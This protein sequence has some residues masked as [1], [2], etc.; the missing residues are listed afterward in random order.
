M[1]GLDNQVFA[2]GI[3]ETIGC[4]EAMLVNFPEAKIDWEGPDEQGVVLCSWGPGGRISY[5]LRLVP[6]DDFIDVEMTVR[7]HTEFRAYVFAFNCINPTQNGGPF[8]IGS[9]SGPT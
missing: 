8:R 3:P 6:A 2:L 9:W 4:R 5:T 7:N 1:P